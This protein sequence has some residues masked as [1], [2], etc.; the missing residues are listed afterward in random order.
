MHLALADCQIS[1]ISDANCQM[2]H[3]KMDNA[4]DARR[5]S[6]IKGEVGFTRCA[7]TISKAANLRSTSNNTSLIYGQIYIYKYI[8]YR[9][10]AK[11][12]VQ[13]HIVFI[14]INVTINLLHRGFFFPFV[15]VLAHHL[16]LFLNL[17]LNFLIEV[18]PVEFLDRVDVSFID[19][20]NFYK[21]NKSTVTRQ[22]N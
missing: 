4:E 19:I 11:A 12:Q 20:S 9:H 2:L 6:R 17:N 18:W 15:L 22:E 13:V 16:C 21:W 8:Q 7:E 10:Y 5:K 1:H 3:Q 14:K